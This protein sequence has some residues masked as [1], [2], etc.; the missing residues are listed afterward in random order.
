M[1]DNLTPIEPIELK[2]NAEPLS[3]V[4]MNKPETMDFPDAIRELINGRRIARV[5]WHNADYGVLKDGWLTIF[6]DGTFRTWLVND[7]DLTSDD[8]QVLVDLN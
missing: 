2:T 8:W 3:P 5:E 6:K 1:D 4:E 7:G